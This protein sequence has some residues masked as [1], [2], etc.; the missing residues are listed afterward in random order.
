LKTSTLTRL[1]TTAAVLGALATPAVA[2]AHEEGIVLPGAS[3]NLSLDYVTNY[4]FRGIEQTDS[5]SG[6]VLQ[7]GASFTIPV[8]DEYTATVGTWGSIHTD[9]PTATSNPGNWFEQDLFASIDG[10]IAEG[11]SGSVGLTYYTFPS[12]AV[13]TDVTE[14]NLAISFDDSELLGEYAFAPYVAVA[15][16]LQNNVAADENSYLEIGGAFAIDT[17]GSFAEGWEVSVPV[18]AGFSLDNYYVDA[19]GAEEF[20]GYASAGVTGSISMEELIGTAEYVGAWDLTA[21]VIVVFMN[22]DI[23]GVISDNSSDIQVIGTL[24]LS[25][26]Y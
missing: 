8:I 24:G 16:E 3:A 19:S 23:N 11:F 26:D 13:N 15:I 10:P 17:E 21:G 6:I 14:L 7:P 12:S 22:G 4:F 25:R 9:A 1:F 18:V 5:D 20:F 2:D